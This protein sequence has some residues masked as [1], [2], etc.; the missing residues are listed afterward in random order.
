MGQMEGRR[1]SLH[2]TLLLITG[3][4]VQEPVKRER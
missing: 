3:S 1:S 2:A 4:K